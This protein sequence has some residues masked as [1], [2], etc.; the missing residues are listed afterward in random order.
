M[1]IFLK[2]SPM[3]YLKQLFL[4]FIDKM[5]QASAGGARK[6]GWLVGWLVGS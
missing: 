1:N 2:H 5:L 4:Q 3:L 6:S